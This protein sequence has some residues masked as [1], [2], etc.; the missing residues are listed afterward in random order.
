MKDA[1]IS[2]FEKHKLEDLEQAM[3][4]IKKAEEINKGLDHSRFL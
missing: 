1:M 3:K 2:E 4:I